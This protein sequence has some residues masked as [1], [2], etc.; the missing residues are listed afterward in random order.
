MD[1]VQIPKDPTGLKYVNR[2]DMTAAWGVS[3]RAGV[4]IVW[5]R[6]PKCGTCPDLQHEIAPNGDVNPSIWHQC[7]T[8]G[9]NVDM[10]DW[11]IWGTLLDWDPA[12]LQP[13][14]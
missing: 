3:D 12:L 5:V 8:S 4:K 11:H 7:G 10:E 6:C 2:N 1:R 9:A 14:V 13:G